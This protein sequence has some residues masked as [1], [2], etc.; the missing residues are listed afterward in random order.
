MSVSE[1]KQPFT[2]CKDCCFAIYQDKTQKGCALNRLE[3]FEVIEAY[4]EDKEFF[5]VNGRQCNTMRKNNG[6]FASKHL[7]EARAKAVRDEIRLRLTVVVPFEK[8]SYLDE[9]ART[10]ISLK[11]QRLTPHQVIFLNLQE[12]IA[13]GKVHAVL[14]ETLENSITWRLSQAASTD[15]SLGAAIDNIFGIIEGQYYSVFLCGSLVP[16]DFIAKLDRLLNDDLK[17]I[18]MFAP[19][20]EGEADGFTIQVPLHKY[21]GGHGDG[22][23]L[24]LIKTV[25]DFAAGMTDK[26]LIGRVEDLCSRA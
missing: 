22:P 11:E 15:I 8:H 7:P 21:M 16:P 12:R 25:K 14:W 6:R 4:D 9:L 20:C 18:A 2:V 5:I 1:L 10:A 13:P 3:K 23:G 19:D 26:N 24:G 17:Q